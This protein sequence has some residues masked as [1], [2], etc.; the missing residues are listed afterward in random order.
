VVALGLGL[1]SGLELRSRSGVGREA[2]V[3]VG[4]G[5]SGWEAIGGYKKGRY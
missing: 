2:G 5:V 1:A 4:G 3:V